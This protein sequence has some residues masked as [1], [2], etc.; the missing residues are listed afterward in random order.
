MLLFY[1]RHG[2]PIYHPDNLTEL[3]LKQA[4]A[5]SKRLIN[6]KIDKIYSSDSVRAVKTAEPT[7]KLYNK[8]IILL[9]WANEHVAW[10]RMTVEKENA[11]PWCFHDGETINKLNS[12]SVRK[13]DIEWHTHP[14][15]SNTLF[16]ECTFIIDTNVDELL[17]NLG[18]KHL[19]NEYRYK[20]VKENDERIAFFAHQGI[21]MS[22]L[23]SILDIPYPIFS[24]RFDFGH[25]SMTVIEFKNVNGYAIPR[26]LQLSND[27]HLYK[28]DILT[29]YQNRLDF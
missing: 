19:R 4:N 14:D 13:M 6:A 5:L 28:E 26:D 3:G 25:S 15:F 11:K 29:G 22:I 18:Y 10:T 2:D 17:L 23:S 21:G 27:A 16:S 12:P 7:A 24:T 8:E 20:V 1:I 9:P